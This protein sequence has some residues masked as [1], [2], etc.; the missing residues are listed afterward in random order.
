MYNAA[1]SVEGGMTDAARILIG[2]VMALTVTDEEKKNYFAQSSVSN[3]INAVLS[4]RLNRLF[5][6]VEKTFKEKVVEI[7][8]DELIVD[9]RT[10]ADIAD[11][12][13][14]LIELKKEG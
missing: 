9:R 1:S 7:L 11:R 10:M 13:N 5:T 14:A 4:V 6:P 12:V 3:T 8:V 2:A